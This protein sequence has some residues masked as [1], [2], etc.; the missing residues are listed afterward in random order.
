MLRYFRAFT[1]SWFGPVIMG[2]ILVALTFLGTGGVRNLLGG[3]FANSVVSAGSRQVSETQFQKM[4]QR[5][6]E[7]YQ[8]RTGQTFPLEE[9]IR[10]GADKTMLEQLAGQTAYAEMLAQSGIRPSDDVVAQELKRQAESGKAPGLAQMFDAVTGKFRPEA[11]TML[12]RNNGITIDQFQRE[13]ADEIA[14]N[15]FQGAI[16]PDIEVLRTDQGELAERFGDL[17]SLLNPEAALAA[18]QAKAGRVE[19]PR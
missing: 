14:D 12:L 13:L 10:Q 1:K 3:R 15:D 17:Y 19:K 9:A 16:A 4:F 5:N 7:A 11:L 6:E 8:E 18:R 2:A